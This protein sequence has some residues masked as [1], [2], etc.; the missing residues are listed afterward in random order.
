MRRTAV[1][2]LPS[3][4]PHLTYCVPWPSLVP[5]VSVLLLNW[6]VFSVTSCMLSSAEMQDTVLGPFLLGPATYIYSVLSV[7]FLG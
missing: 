3:T 7:L 6:V 5:A 2:G 4:W 1:P